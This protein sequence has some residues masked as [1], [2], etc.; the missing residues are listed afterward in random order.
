MGWR[1][2]R[3]VRLF[4]GMRL[5]LGKSGPSLSLGVRGF[6]ETFGRRGRRTTVGL[7]GT[8]ISYSTHSSRRRRHG[9]TL[10]GFLTLALIIWVI[11]H[12]LQ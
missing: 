3:S 7:S 2:R 11:Y 5:N 8:G 4:P 6:H 10:G 9:A 12:A 1:F